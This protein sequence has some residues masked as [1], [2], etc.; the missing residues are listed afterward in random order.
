MHEQAQWPVPSI[1]CCSE[2]ATPMPAEAPGSPGAY[3]TGADA[4][5][6]TPQALTA[7]ELA[8]RSTLCAR[9]SGPTLWG[10]CAWA[11]QVARCWPMHTAAHAMA[12]VA[13]SP[14]PAASWRIR[15]SC[16]RCCST[17]RWT[18]ASVQAVLQPASGCRH[19]T[20]RE[21]SGQAGVHCANITRLC[22]GFTSAGAVKM[23]PG[24]LSFGR[25]YHRCSVQNACSMKWHR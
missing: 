14:R 4:L 5:A 17:G 10:L 1:C 7:A 16:V 23:R 9:C 19:S 2:P 25:K 11:R 8:L 12:S 22:R 13:P 6:S 3:P 20:R 21:T 15:P 24:H 18:W